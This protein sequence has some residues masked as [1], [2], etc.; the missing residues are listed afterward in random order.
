VS[1]ALRMIR[2][3]VDQHRTKRG[4]QMKEVAVVGF[5]LVVILHLASGLSFAERAEDCQ[6]L[7]TRAIDFVKDKGSDYAFRVFSAS[8]GPFIDKELYVFACSLD[9]IMLAHPYQRDLIGQ[10]VDEFKDAK[11]H[12]LFQEFRK[13]AEVGGQGWVHYWWPKPGENGTFPKA[14]FIMKVP[15]E[16]LY[17]GAGYYKT[18]GAERH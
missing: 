13:V 3:Q 2:N 16:K 7:V 12:L 8:K 15:G 4:K 1:H 14:S 10:N 17:V 6:T 9:N 11:G 5:V 18:A